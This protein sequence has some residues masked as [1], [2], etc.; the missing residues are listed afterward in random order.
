MELTYPVW[1]CLV[2]MCI[3]FGISMLLSPFV[4]GF[5]N[6]ASSVP[7]LDFLADTLA[8]KNSSESFSFLHR[9]AIL[10][11]PWSGL[12]GFA[13]RFLFYSALIYAKG[14]ELIHLLVR[15]LCR[16]SRLLR[17]LCRFLPCSIFIKHNH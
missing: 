5:V 13:G 14:F 10:V 11:A 3:G 6:A 1:L 17:L 9:G 16:R 4:A 15:Q 2:A 12:K 7:L 8:S